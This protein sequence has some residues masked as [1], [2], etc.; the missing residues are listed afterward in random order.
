MIGLD[1]TSSLSV[2]YAMS[3]SEI[4]VVL[5]DEK[6]F[7]TCQ[8]NADV[9]LKGGYGSASE[10]TVG[11]TLAS[12]EVLHLLNEGRIRV[13][14]SVTGETLD[15]RSLLK[16]LETTD[17]EAWTKYLIYRDLRSRGY[18]VRE[19]VGWGITFRAYERGA[20]G[21]KAAK[22]I[23]FA[24]CEGNPIP[25]DRLRETLEMAQNMKKEIIVAVMDRRGEM[26]YYSL[27]QL[28]LR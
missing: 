20:Y 17:S 25:V 18:V 14:D 23:V 13:V 22:F 8:E 3:E 21:E 4:E 11:S 9:L 10:G 24:I 26:V 7:I 15:L 5:R 2:V 1:D 19:G 12:Y 28:D 16:R 6:V 27:S